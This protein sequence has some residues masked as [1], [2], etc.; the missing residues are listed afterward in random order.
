MDRRRL[1]E[2]LLKQQ[3]SFYN[4]AVPPTLRQATLLAQLKDERK[5]L[6]EKIGLLFSHPMY[7]RLLNVL[8]IFDF[9]IIATRTNYTSETGQVDLNWTFIV[10]C[11]LCGAF[12]LEVALLIYVQGAGNVFSCRNWPLTLDVL[13]VLLSTLG[14][15]FSGIAHGTGALAAQAI[16]AVIILRLLRLSRLIKVFIGVGEE[17][18]MEGRHD[19]TPRLCLSGSLPLRACAHHPKFSFQITFRTK[20]DREAFLRETT[21]LLQSQS[22]NKALGGLWAE[23]GSLTYKSA[24]SEV[25]S[26]SRRRVSSSDGGMGVS[27]LR[28]D[29]ETKSDPVPVGHVGVTEC[30]HPEVRPHAD[31]VR[32]IITYSSLILVAAFPQLANAIARQERSLLGSTTIHGSL[33]STSTSGIRR[34]FSSQLMGLIGYRTQHESGVQMR[35]IASVQPP[36][37]SHAARQRNTGGTSFHYRADLSEAE[38]GSGFR[39]THANLPHATVH[40]SAAVSRLETPQSRAEAGSGAREPI[41]EVWIATCRAHPEITAVQG[42]LSVPILRIMLGLPAFDNVQVEN[43]W[44]QSPN[45]TSTAEEGSLP[46]FPST[47]S[48]HSALRRPRSLHHKLS[49]GEEHR[50]VSLLAVGKEDF[51]EPA[52]PP[53]QPSDEYEESDSTAAGYISGSD[54]GEYF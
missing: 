18:Y 17:R 6:R 39:P 23:E 51:E 47:A 52:L 46:R 36:R 41:T 5:S 45:V 35:E 38:A 53:S 13:V 54:V 50:K 7:L 27:E 21:H 40:G 48:A 25:P 33:P 44:K 1:S 11:I 43:E 29:G 49:L 15:I 3:R 20:A 10:E 31:G 8:I 2:A 9:I 26:A 30:I 4:R 19:F 28:L 16:Q 12:C 32:V 37:G 34:V 42:G 24:H 14:V 22:D